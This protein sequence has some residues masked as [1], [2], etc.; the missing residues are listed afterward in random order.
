MKS[1]AA[2][3]RVAVEH[4]P[5][6]NRIAVGLRVT[7]ETRDDL[8][9]RAAKAGTSLTSQIENLLQKAMLFERLAGQEV[10]NALWDF[11]SAGAR[12]A[13]YQGIAGDWTRDLNCFR[14][15]LR[16]AVERL[17]EASPEWDGEGF[18]HDLDHALLTAQTRWQQGIARRG[19]SQ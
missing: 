18:K 15:A 3:R 1:K 10:L 13:A 14:R 7:P 8:A 5:P 4:S 16:A 6:R 17:L 12:E 19:A 2:A 9:E 11:H